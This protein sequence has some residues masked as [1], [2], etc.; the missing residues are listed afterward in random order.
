[1]YTGIIEHNRLLLGCQNFKQVSDRGTAC[2]SAGTRLGVKP[3]QSISHL[4]PNYLHFQS[5]THHVSSG[6]PAHAVKKVV[7]IQPSSAA[8][9]RIFSLLTNSFDD[10]Q[11]NCLEDYVEASLMLQYNSR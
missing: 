3:Q 2:N 4:V 11:Q 7:L 8:S 1:M 5:F 10:K 9:E 6:T